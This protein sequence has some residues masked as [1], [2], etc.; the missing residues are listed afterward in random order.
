MHDCTFSSSSVR[1]RGFCD[2]LQIRWT[3][4]IEVERLKRWSFSPISLIPL[5]AFFEVVLIL[6]RVFEIFDWSEIETRIVVVECEF[7]G[8]EKIPKVEEYI[9]IHA[10]T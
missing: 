5:L 7:S 3:W 8:N 9:L 6:F 1:G 2:S 4:A 10:Y